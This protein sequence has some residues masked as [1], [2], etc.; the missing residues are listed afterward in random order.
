VE[1][2]LTA[3]IIIMMVSGEIFQTHL[4]E[5]YNMEEFYEEDEEEVGG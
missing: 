3:G 1:I 2:G 5:E 4:I